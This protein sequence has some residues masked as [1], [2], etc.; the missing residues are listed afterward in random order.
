MIVSGDEH[1]ST[2]PVS[3]SWHLL[4]KTLTLGP[5]KETGDLPAPTSLILVKNKEISDNFAA[6]IRK[7]SS[8][9]PVRCV[10]FHTAVNI[11]KQAL[12]L[13]KV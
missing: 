3:F 10:N 11:K 12:E 1:R 9:S 8:G 4:H 6:D 5:A 7:T 13:T 2:L